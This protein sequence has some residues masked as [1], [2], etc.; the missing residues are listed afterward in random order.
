METRRTSALGNL[1]IRDS[2]KCIFSPEQNLLLR[3]NYINLAKP[4]IV[5][6]FPH[7]KTNIIG[8]QYRIRKTRN[9]WPQLLKM[10]TLLAV[11]IAEKTG[12]APPEELV[13]K[14]VTLTI[15]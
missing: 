10:L 6:F 4:I 2:R 14:K 13:M 3:S 15:S 11:Y 8:E 9:H 5:P 1:L 12:T 7:K